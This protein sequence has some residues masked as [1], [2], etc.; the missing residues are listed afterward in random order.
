MGVTER[1]LADLA[2]YFDAKPSRPATLSAGGPERGV[3]SVP[4]MLRPDT[5]ETPF[6]PIEKLDVLVDRLSRRGP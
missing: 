2:A 1:G 6:N 5:V 3:L 4:S